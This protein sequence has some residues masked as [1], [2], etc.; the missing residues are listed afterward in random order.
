[1]RKFNV[2]FVKWDWIELFNILAGNTNTINYVNTEESRSI[3]KIDLVSISDELTKNLVKYPN[4]LY[5]LSSRKFEELVTYIMAKYGYD[6]TLTQQSRDGGVDIFAVKKDGFGSFL[7]LVDCKKYSQNR[8][9][10]VDLVRTMYGTLNIEKASHGIIATTSRFT[11]DAQ[12][13]AKNYSYQKSLKD[14]S[15]II[16]WMKG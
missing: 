5:E 1:M 8:P 11:N 6:V 4:L 10:G 15:D 12:V 16:G 13:L 14:H 3:I 7:T 9:V 2:T